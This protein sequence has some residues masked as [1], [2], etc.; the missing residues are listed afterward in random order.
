MLLELQIV[1]FVFGARAGADVAT[2]HI[3]PNEKISLIGY[4]NTIKSFLLKVLTRQYLPNRVILEKAKETTIYCTSIK[5][6][7]NNSVNFFKFK[8]GD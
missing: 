2:L 4:Y 3:H 5:G 8:S 7:V 1:T 6:L